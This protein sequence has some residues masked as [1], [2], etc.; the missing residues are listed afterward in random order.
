MSSVESAAIGGCASLGGSILGNGETVGT[1]RILLLF[2]FSLVYE[3]RLFLNGIV[4][5]GFALVMQIHVP[6]R[7]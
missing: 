5:F 3:L 7:I 6:I 2:V 1:S 4:I